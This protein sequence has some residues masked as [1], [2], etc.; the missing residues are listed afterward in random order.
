MFLGEALEQLGQPALGV[1]NLHLEIRG[2]LRGKVDGPTQVSLRV[3]GDVLGETKVA[4]L[5]GAE[6]GGRV[7]GPR[8]WSSITGP[9]FWRHPATLDEIL[10]LGEPGGPTLHLQNGDLAYGEHT[11]IEGW[12]EV[13]VA[14]E[15][16]ND[17]PDIR[18]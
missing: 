7:T 15:V 6:F 10:D 11:D 17:L 13:I 4:H 16:W 12:R 2:S 14:G 8:T 1:G 3:G 9:V 18:D 5:S